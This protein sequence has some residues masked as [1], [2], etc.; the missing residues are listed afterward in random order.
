MQEPAAVD[1]LHPPLEVTAPPV[2]F[3]LD[4]EVVCEKL[5]KDA[6]HVEVIAVGVRNSLRHSE[7]LGQEGIPVGRQPEGSLEVLLG[8]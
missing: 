7:R 1:L 4:G 2:V 6:D 3:T 5:L 8:R